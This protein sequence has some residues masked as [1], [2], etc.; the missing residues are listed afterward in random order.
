M[1]CWG[2]GGTRQGWR[3]CST[4]RQ[5]NNLPI[6]PANR[7]LNGNGGGNTDLQSSPIHDK[8]GIN[9][10]R[11][12]RQAGMFTG[13]DY[14]NPNPWVRMLGKANASKIEIDGVIQKALIDSG[15][16]IS[17]MSKEYC[18]EYEYAIQPLDQLVPIECS[19]G[20]LSLLRLH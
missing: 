9:I 12:L 20:Q 11:Q 18:D 16:M 2:C 6:K 10:H 1:L 14:Y 5:G 15:A 13:P 7:N 8:G 3:E 17:M 19:G 4:L